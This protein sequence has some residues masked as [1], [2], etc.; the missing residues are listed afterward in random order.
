MLTD[1]FIELIDHI[2]KK[3]TESQNLEVKSAHRGMPKRLYG[4]LSSFSN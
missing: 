2:L 4:T 1:G 3:E